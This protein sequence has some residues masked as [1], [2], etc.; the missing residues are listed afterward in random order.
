M[1]SSGL[2]GPQVLSVRRRGVPLCQQWLSRYRRY[3][4]SKYGCKLQEKETLYKAV[5]YSMRQRPR[6]QSVYFGST[7]TGEAQELCPQRSKKPSPQQVVDLREGD[8]EQFEREG[9]G[10]DPLR[11]ALKAE[12]D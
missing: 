9:P 8:V 11:S 4:L 2:E 10:I 12:V 6:P 7:T 5:V 1:K 3:R